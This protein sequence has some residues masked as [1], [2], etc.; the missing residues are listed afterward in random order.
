MFLDGGGVPGAPGR[1]SPVHAFCPADIEP[2]DRA[3]LARIE[4][5]ASVSAEE[6]TEIED[7]FKGAGIET[8]ISSD[9]EARSIDVPWLLY[10]T[11]PA[12]WMTSKFAGAIAE[13][14]A[15]DTYP[16]LKELVGRLTNARSRSGPSGRIVITDETSNCRILVSDLPDE[17]WAAL[18]EIELPQDGYLGWQKSSSKWKSV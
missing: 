7:I 18:A 4:L 13:E 15:K 16:A 6:I 2:D 5:D 10:V 14:A 1:T 12:L 11:A 8:S 3:P 17:A 9:W